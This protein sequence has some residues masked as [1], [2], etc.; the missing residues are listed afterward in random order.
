[1]QNHNEKSGWFAPKYLHPKLL[2]IPE[3]TSQEMIVAR[4]DELITDKKDKPMGT[5]RESAIKIGLGFCKI[6]SAVNIMNI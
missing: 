1:M 5:A 3:E 2:T 6:A 4:G